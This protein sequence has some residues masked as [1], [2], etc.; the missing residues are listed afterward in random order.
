AIEQARQRV[1]AGAGGRESEHIVQVISLYNGARYSAYTFRRYDDVRLVMAPELQLGYFGGDA[2]NFTYPRYSLDMSFLRVYEN[3]QPFQTEHFFPWSTGGAAEGETVFVVGNPGSTNRLETVAQLEYRRDISERYLFDWLNS[4]VEALEQY[5]EEDPSDAV[6]NQLFSLLNAQ[7]LYRGRLRG[8]ED[9]V[10]MARRRDTEAQFRAAIEAS[11]E[12]REEY[13]SLIDEM[14]ELQQ[15]RRLLE[16]EFAAFF[17]LTP[18][19]SLGSTVMRRAMLAARLVNLRE[20]G[21][22]EEQQAA[23]VGQILSIGD[24]PEMLQEMYLVDRL[25]ALEEHIADQSA[26]LANLLAA[27]DT[28][29]LAADIVQSSALTDSAETARAIDEGELEEDA[30]VQ[31]ALTFSDIFA[32]YTSASAGIAA[33]EQELAARLGRARFEVYGTSIPPD[34]TFSLRI[35]DG[36]VSGYPYNGTIAPSHTTYYGM[37]DRFFAFGPGTEWDLPPVWAQVPESLELSTPLN[38]VSTNDIIGGNSGSPLLNEDLEL[39]GLVFD[40][41]I[42]SLPSSFIYVTERA[43]AVSVDSRG[44]LEALRAVYRADR[45]AD[46]LTTGVAVN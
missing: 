33:Q 42:E 31:L 4:R 36:V 34:A 21:A 10:L 38:L 35:A 5:V 2:D 44:M 41:N 29:S 37:Y 30:A 12:L 13:G 17:G 24:Q 14:A 18:T 25:E 27:D 39:V 1:L 32:D 7:K 23:L 11:P 28:E 6:R 16:D 19:S 20:A 43:R 40:G 3:D 9:P 8:L 15:E 22:P 46:E 26:A 45:I